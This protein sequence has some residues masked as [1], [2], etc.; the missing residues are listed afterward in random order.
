MKFFEESDVQQVTNSSKL[1]LIRVWEFLMEF[2][3]CETG[4]IINFAG[5]AALA[6]VCDL[7]VIL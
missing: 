3:H 1:V 7:H 6:E 2:C 5:S 4:A